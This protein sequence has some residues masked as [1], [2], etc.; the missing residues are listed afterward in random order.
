V[1]L[2]TNG[3]E[4]ITLPFAIS[5]DDI[6]AICQKK[7][8]KGSYP[9]RQRLKVIE[10]VLTLVRTS[11]QVVNALPSEQIWPANVKHCPQS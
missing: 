8:S 6:L 10:Q 5:P 7:K 9:A 4:R 3:T 1:A 2:D 11:V